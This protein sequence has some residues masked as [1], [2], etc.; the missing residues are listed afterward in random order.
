VDLNFNFRKSLVKRVTGI[1]HKGKKL[2]SPTS[3]HRHPAYGHEMIYVDYGKVYL[4]I[5]DSSILVKPGEC[6]LIPGGAMHSF[7][8]EKGTYFDYLNIMFRGRLPDTIFR[9][10]LP[11]NSHCHRLM[12]RLK[13]ESIQDIPH[14]D[15]LIA[16]NLTIIIVHLLR[17]L[18]VAMPSRPTNPIYNQ[19]YHSEIVNKALS[20]ISNSYSHPINLKQLGKAVGVSKSH[21]H[22]LLKKETGKNFSLLLQEHRVAAAKHLLFDSAFPIQKIANAVGYSALPFFFKIFK[23]ITGMTP[24]EYSQSLGEPAEKM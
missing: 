3:C 17:E 7:S 22:F 8:G 16:A 21:L 10:S 4:R 14:R 13:Q 9:R 2:D 15:E 11:V 20:A 18:T 1:G 5:D 6:V 23:R 19:R 12:E 24:K